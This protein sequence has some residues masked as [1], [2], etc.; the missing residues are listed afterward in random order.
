MKTS[1]IITGDSDKESKI[2]KIQNVFHVN[3]NLTD[4]KFV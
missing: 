1:S 4:Q 2:R 3:L